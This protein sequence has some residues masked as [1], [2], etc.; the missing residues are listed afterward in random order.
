MKRIILSY[1]ETFAIAFGLAILANGES[2]MG[3]GG[4]S[5]AESAAAAAILAGVR[6]GVLAVRIRLT[7]PSA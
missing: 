5:A 7:K 6:A 2:I 1:L 3:A 4:W